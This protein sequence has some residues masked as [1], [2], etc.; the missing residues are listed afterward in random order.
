M[1]FVCQNAGAAQRPV[2]VANLTVFRD[3]KSMKVRNLVEAAA[4]RGC[5]SP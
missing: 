4:A 1:R 3:A 5:F 2:E